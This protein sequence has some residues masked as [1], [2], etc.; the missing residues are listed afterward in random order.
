MSTCIDLG[1]IAFVKKLS[2]MCKKVLEKG[3]FFWEIVAV[4][5]QGIFQMAELMFVIPTENFLF[6]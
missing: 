6:S 3:A 2:W 1:V 5:F 4:L